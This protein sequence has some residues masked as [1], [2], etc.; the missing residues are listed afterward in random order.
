MERGKE[1]HL[2]DY[3]PSDLADVSY[4]GQSFDDT[5]PE[6][7]KYYKTEQ[8]LPWAVN[9][10]SK[11]EYP[12]ETVSIDLAHLKFIEWVLSDGE[13]YNNW[14]KDEP[15]YRNNANIYDEE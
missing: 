1:V 11:F 6:I 5:Q 2:P 7:G 8:N 12:I 13:D 9:F 10:P 3:L 15:G 14:Y 4:F